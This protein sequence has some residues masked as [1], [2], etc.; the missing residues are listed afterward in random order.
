MKSFLNSTIQHDWTD[1]EF[2]TVFS[3]SR[4][5]LTDQKTVDGIRKIHYGDIRATYEN[6]IP[7]FEILKIN[8]GKKIGK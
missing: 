7:D 1:P 8:D 4:E 3:F 6:E 2:V 5:Q